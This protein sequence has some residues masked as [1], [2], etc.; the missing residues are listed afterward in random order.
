MRL[1]EERS[2]C[3]LFVTNTPFD[4]YFISNDTLL[5]LRVYARKLKDERSGSDNDEG[6]IDNGGVGSS[7][8]F[9]TIEMLPFNPHRT[10]TT[11]S[12]F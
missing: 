6:Y 7:K 9:L 2:L 10:A 12:P 3:R 8:A 5:R 11:Q 4:R 1:L